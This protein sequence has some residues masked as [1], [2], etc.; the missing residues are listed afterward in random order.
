MEK[1]KHRVE[2]MSERVEWQYQDQRGQTVTF[3][4]E[5]NCSLEEALQRGGNPKIRI[6]GETY[7]TDIKMRKA[8]SAKSS[9]TVELLRVDKKGESNQN[10]V[11]LSLISRSSSP[12]SLSAPSQRFCR[13]TG[14]T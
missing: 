14:P 4:L 8:Y 5:T 12:R 11:T 13:H 10:L 6:N 7:V 3:D 2:E 1:L 9:D